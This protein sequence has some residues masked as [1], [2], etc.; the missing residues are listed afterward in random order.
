MDPSF[1]SEYLLIADSVEQV[2][3]AVPHADVPDAGDAVVR[4]PGAAATWSMDGDNKAY[5][6]PLERV[7]KRARRTGARGDA[8]AAAQRTVSESVVPDAVDEVPDS[9]DEVPYSVDEDVPDAVEDDV[10]DAVEEVPD[11]DEVVDCPRCRTFH[12]GGVFGEAYRQAHRN[13]RRCA[14]CGLLHEDYDLVTQVLDGM[15]NFDCK[16]YIPVVEELQLEG[17]TIILPEQV[18]QKL[19]EMNQARKSAKANKEGEAS[20]DEASKQ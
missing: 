14:R 13:A 9:V 10:P 18:V 16:F 4:A 3:D 5:S 8:A 1:G 2:P 15:E 19:D 11:V 7:H 20:K 17:N 12:A 6:T